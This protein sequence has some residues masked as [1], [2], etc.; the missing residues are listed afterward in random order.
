LPIKENMDIV[1]K[2]LAKAQ[3]DAMGDAWV[4]A[5]QLQKDTGISPEDL[6]NAVELLER[7]GL[8]KW[9]Q[10]L[11]TATFK[12]FQASITIKGRLSIER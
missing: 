3:K 8:V 12:F 5:T 1:I 4:E 7:D 10:V 6:N 9:R 11:E 2:T